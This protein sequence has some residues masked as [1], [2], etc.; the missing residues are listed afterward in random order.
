VEGLLFLCQR[1]ALVV[2]TLFGWE[3]ELKF[4]DRLRQG[5]ARRGMFL[6]P[7]Q[8]QTKLVTF[9]STCSNM[10]PILFPLDPAHHVLADLFNHDSNQ[11]P[12]G[13]SWSHFKHFGRT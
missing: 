6:S 4:F 2:I 10:I 13:T 12:P 5:R 8:W 7:L 3:Q 1:V 11:L 9:W